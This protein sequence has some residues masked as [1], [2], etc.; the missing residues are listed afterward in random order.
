MLE[1][2]G[3]RGAGRG[4]AGQGGRGAG[5]ARHLPPGASPASPR[6]AR[7]HGTC[8]RPVRHRPLHP[9]PP[10]RPPPLRT[11][12]SVTAAPDS[13]GVAAKGHPAGTQTP[14]KSPPRL[15]SPLPADPRSPHGSAGPGTR[16][17]RGEGGL[18]GSGQGSGRG[19]Q[20]PPPPAAAGAG[21]QPRFLFRLRFS[22]AGVAFSG[23]RPRTMRGWASAGRLSLLPAPRSWPPTL[24]PPTLPWG[25][26]RAVHP[27]CYYP[28]LSHD[29]GGGGRIPQP[30]SPHS[31]PHLPA[32]PAAP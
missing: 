15:I 7:P 13:A 27:P 16:R 2:R 21:P 29:K 22:G 17:S 9:P 31:I 30:R 10:R 26:C 12:R 32:S 11:A 28:P 20:A 4:G 3:G 25:H 14:S 19:P 5:R 24:L 23:C 18:A 6:T 1:R 8:S